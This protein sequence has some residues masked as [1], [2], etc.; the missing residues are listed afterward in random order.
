MQ[1]NACIVLPAEIW[2][3]VID[4]LH[5]N[6]K[7]LKRC[8]LVCK[9]WRNSSQHHLFRTV[10]LKSGL[11]RAKELPVLV[12]MGYHVVD[13]VLFG[14][15]VELG[16]LKRML[17]SLTNVQKLSM[18]SCQVLFSIPISGLPALKLSTLE[19]RDGNTLICDNAMLYR[20]LSLFQS[21][22]TLSLS[23]HPLWIMP[24]H[25]S[26]AV[27]LL[28]NLRITSLSI[29][30]V[31]IGL[32]LEII[33]HSQLTESLISLRL[34]FTEHQWV[35]F[36]ALGKLLQRVGPTLRRLDFLPVYKICNDAIGPNAEQDLKRWFPSTLASCTAFERFDFYFPI[37][38]YGVPASHTFTTIYLPFLEH[39]VSPL[40]EVVFHANTH[41]RG[42]R[43]GVTSH[44]DVV[45]VPDE[46][47]LLDVLF[48][49]NARLANT[50]VVFEF[51]DIFPSLTRQD[52]QEV[53]EFLREGLPYISR[54]DRLVVTDQPYP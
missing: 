16:A 20:L 46:I 30:K 43:Y 36:Q 13:L 48:Q 45:L 8:S 5:D 32:P 10:V 21:I 40:R 7:A 37:T 12:A 26:P 50:R 1:D 24:T 53:L 2:D 14:Q 49:K 35:D 15:A 9:S 22:D 19:I 41:K 28:E 39:T 33:R 6:K 34:V 29:E 3:R 47:V 31:S 25:A 27:R 51:S 52:L 18:R 4:H 11:W 42:G 23:L 38:K 44:T 17:H 54:S